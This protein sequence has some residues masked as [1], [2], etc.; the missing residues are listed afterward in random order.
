[1]WARPLMARELFSLGDGTCLKVTIAEYFLPSG[2]S[3]HKKGVSPDVE[4]EYEANSDDEEADNQL[5]KA[6]EVIGEEVQ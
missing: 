4:V 6:L 2:R 1:M 5:E 3:I